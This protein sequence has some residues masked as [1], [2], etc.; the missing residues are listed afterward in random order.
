MRTLQQLIRGVLQDGAALPFDAAAYGDLPGAAAAPALY[1]VGVSEAREQV[2]LWR[3][4]YDGSILL[5]PCQEIFV[6][7]ER[8]RPLIYRLGLTLRLQYCRYAQIQSFSVCI[9]TLH[10]QK[11]VDS[12]EVRARGVKGADGLPGSQVAAH[13]LSIM[14]RPRSQPSGGSGVPGSARLL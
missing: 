4:V 5:L 10:H 11:K 8:N 13:W 1:D 14:S 7:C 2:A 3:M 12:E 9:D 6:I